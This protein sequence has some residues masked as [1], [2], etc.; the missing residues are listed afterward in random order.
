[1]PAQQVM[2]PASVLNTWASLLSIGIV[3]V[4]LLQHLPSLSSFTMTRTKVTPYLPCAKVC[5]ICCAPLVMSGSTSL[6]N[7]WLS[8]PPIWLD[9]VMDGVPLGDA[10][11][12]SLS[13]TVPHHRSLGNWHSITVIDNHGV[14]LFLLGCLFFFQSWLFG[15]SRTTINMSSSKEINALV[16]LFNGVE[17]RAWKESVT[18]CDQ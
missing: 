12:C 16:P 4:Q 14:V 8:W 7:P 17:Y 6:V 13:V 11:G 10:T 9:N 2:G 1:M 5:T 15:L 3:S 18:T